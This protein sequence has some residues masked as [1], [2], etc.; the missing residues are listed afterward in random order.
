M[1]KIT[2]DIDSVTHITSRDGYRWDVYRG[3]SLTSAM[4]GTEQ[5]ARE[6]AVTWNRSDVQI[7]GDDQR[8]RRERRL[9][10]NGYGTG[11]RAPR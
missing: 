8:E 11:Y 1:S 3:G 9:A 2:I 5:Q 7:V 6:R 4:W 10:E